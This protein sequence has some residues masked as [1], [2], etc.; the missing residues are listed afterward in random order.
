MALFQGCEYPVDYYFHAGVDDPSD[1][2]LTIPDEPLGLGS[3]FEVVM[4]F[5]DFDF[6]AMGEERLVEEEGKLEAVSFSPTSPLVF[7][8]VMWF[9]ECWPVL[10]DALYMAT[11]A[12]EGPDME[13]GL[14][15]CDFGDDAR[16]GDERSNMGASYIPYIVVK[17]F[18]EVDDA[19]GGG[20]GLGLFEPVSDDLVELFFSSWYEF[21]WVEEK[22]FKA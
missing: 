22:F 7:R 5:L 10:P 6:L 11:D 2:A 4:C 20:H 19:Y 1:I 9:L 18:R 14:Y 17:Y 8:A 15:R 3:W 12:P 21:L 16:H 13:K